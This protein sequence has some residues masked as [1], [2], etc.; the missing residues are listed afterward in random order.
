[1]DAKDPLS[2]LRGVKQRRMLDLVLGCL[3]ALCALKAAMLLRH[4]STGESLVFLAGG[5]L[6]FS[7]A[8]RKK[9]LVIAALAFLTVVFLQHWTLSSLLMGILGALLL[10]LILL[11]EP[12][13][14]RMPR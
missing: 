13:A 7:F 10:W 5:L 9:R 3:L 12:K 14:D 11:R 8:T 4:G 1:M 2:K 6:L